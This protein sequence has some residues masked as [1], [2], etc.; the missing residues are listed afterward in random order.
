MST[1]ILCTSDWHTSPQNLSQCEVVVQQILEVIKREHCSYIL[2]LGDV[3]DAFNPVDQRA[4]NFLIQAVEEISHLCPILVV[5]GNHDRIG[6][7]DVLDSCLPVVNAAG[8]MTFEIPTVTKLANDLRLSVVPYIRDTQAL[9]KAFLDVLPERRSGLLVFHAEVQGCCLTTQA[10]SHY[11]ITLADV[12]PQKYL[13]CLGGHIHYPQRMGRNLWYVGSPFCHDWG[14]CNQQ[15]GFLL[16]EVSGSSVK[17]KHIPSRVP[18][19]YDSQLPKF[20]R[21]TSWKD[22]HV[23]V[24]VS[25]RHDPVKEM[26]TARA[27]AAEKYLG[28]HLH[29]VPEFELAPAADGLKLK[30]DASDRDVIQQYVTLTKPK[31]VAGEQV[32]AY[33]C[34]T[35]GSGRVL[36]IPRL[37]FRHIKAEN[38]LCFDKYDLDLSVPGLTLVTG[39]N[40]DWDGR[41]NG[42]GKSSLLSLPVVA[43]FGVTPKGQ[44]HDGWC[45]Q[46]ATGKSFVELQ[47]EMANGQSCTIYRSRQ[48]AGLTVHVD[49]R[50]MTPGDI[51]TTQ[52]YIESLT[53]LTWDVLVNALYVGQKEVGTILTG[54]EKERKELF[55]RFLGLER[56]LVAQEKVRDDLRRTRIQLEEVES[57]IAT[58][59]AACQTCQ[60]TLAELPKIVHPD[61]ASV[62]SQRQLEK[63]YLADLA[64]AQVKEHRIDTWLEE[65]QRRFNK[66]LDHTIRADAR[67]EPLEVQL[68]NVIRIQGRCPLCNSQVSAS[69]I[70]VH[71]D[72]L[73][74]QIAELKAEAFAFEGRQAENRKRRLAEITKLHQVRAVVQKYQDKLDALRT[75]LTKAEALA[76]TARAMEATK[77]RLTQQLNNHNRAQTFHAGYRAILLEHVKFLE[78]SQS[79]VGRDGLPT[80]LCSVVVP[81]LNQAANR[82]GEAFTEGAIRVQFTVAEGDLDISIVNTYGGQTVG[83]QS[84]GEL[85][86]A[87]L[88]VAFAF[89]DTL[90]PHNLLILDEPGEGLDAANARA[91][92]RGLAAVV[93]RFGSVF[94]TTHNAYILAELEATRHLEVAK[95]GGVATVRMVYTDPGLRALAGP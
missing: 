18:G 17:V 55:S 53:E 42:A 5:L 73:D 20:R 58:S 64:E 72:S 69:Q 32:V 89:R 48:P 24:R 76:D 2:N 71:A 62:K 54:T 4:T 46:G 52:R 36:G 44:S 9:R 59:L 51:R 22:C 67:R 81:Q 21:P 16:V 47:L 3:K 13:M 91:F 7:S 90:V 94:L 80:Y 8:G 60:Q 43:L 12:H 25:V 30:E 28:A 19:W 41:S 40:H 1:K 86:M 79:V 50:D 87:G 15:K 63:R 29:V 74:H 6:P 92:A 57:E 14:E 26:A 27:A 34:H 61:S 75:W 35:L 88:V 83:D 93:E 39:V 84:M 11:A 82:Y 66:L 37:V 68:E 49:G 78:Y 10:R 33:L 23:R 38:V 45:R 65:N 56:F 85:R 70:Q 31:G 95:S 77:S